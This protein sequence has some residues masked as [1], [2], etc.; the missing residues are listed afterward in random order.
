MSDEINGAGTQ[1]EQ[2]AQQDTRAE[3]RRAEKE[4][5]GKMEF[6]DWVQ[7]FVGALVVGIV[8]FMFGLRVVN[9]KGNSMYP[10]LLWSDRIVTTNFLY[11]PRAGDIVVVQTDTYGPEPLVK[12]VIAT[13]G[14]T[15][16]I[17]FER[18]IVYVDGVA[19][20]EPYI[21]APT[22]TR[23]DFKGPLTVPDGCLF[24]MGDNRNESTDSRRA[25]IG[26]VDERCVIGKVLFV[27]FPAPGS[28][29]S[30]DLGRIG[31]VYG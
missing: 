30:R 18:G 28:D 29:G 20:D 17:D 9:V 16:D 23:E 3:R 6:Y 14:Q 7:C 5:S 19:L 25:T 4:K 10:T 1:P 21:A 22:Y 31:S 12:R 26:T 24:L 13:G 11:T 27:L 2:P 8:I 15:V